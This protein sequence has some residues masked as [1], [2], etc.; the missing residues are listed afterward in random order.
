MYFVQKSLS[1]C[2]QACTSL[3]LAV[4][5]AMPTAAASSQPPSS[6]KKP[7]VVGTNDDISGK[8][9][10]SGTTVRGFFLYLAYRSKKNGGVRS[11]ID[12]PKVQ[13]HAGT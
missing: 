9:A 4:C 7:Y 6:K 12:R 10:Y 8:V 1:R 2:G 11:L 5:A 3:A 13:T